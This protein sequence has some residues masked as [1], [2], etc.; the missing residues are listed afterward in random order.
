MEVKIIEDHIVLRSPRAETNSVAK[1]M[2]KGKNNR[3]MNG[4]QVVYAVEYVLRRYRGR[5]YDVKWIEVLPE[6]ERVGLPLQQLE[7]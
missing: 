3:I 4:R 1:G 2:L 6:L 5:A 7:D